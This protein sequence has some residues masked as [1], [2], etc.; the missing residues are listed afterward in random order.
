MQSER[1]KNLKADE[2]EEYNGLLE[3]QSLPFEEKAI[4]AHEANLKRLGQGLWDANIARSVTALGELSPA[5][6][7][8]KETGEERYETLR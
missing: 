3:E 5:K 4:Q 2:L 6:Y 8:K 7:G 1:P